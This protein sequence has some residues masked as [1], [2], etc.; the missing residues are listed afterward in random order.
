[1]EPWLTW[2]SPQE[3]AV[4]DPHPSEVDMD[5]IEVDQDRL[6]ILKG[7]SPEQKKERIELVFKKEKRARDRRKE[8]EGKSPEEKGKLQDEYCRHCQAERL[9]MADLRCLQCEVEFLDGKF[10]EKEARQAQEL[11]EGCSRCEGRGCGP[12]MVAGGKGNGEPTGEGSPPRVQNLE[13]LLGEAVE[14]V[15]HICPLTN[16]Q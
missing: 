1:M 8:A 15:A 5:D 16:G 3:H 9:D 2:H 4:E 14:H 6:E 7:L 13:K 11:R 12:E 10:E